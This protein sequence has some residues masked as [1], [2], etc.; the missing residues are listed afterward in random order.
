MRRRDI[1]RRHHRASDPLLA[2]VV[3]AIDDAPIHERQIR[4][5]G[6]FVFGECEPAGD[7]TLNVPL[8]RV[9][10]YLHE[11]THRVRPE[12]TETT[13]RRRSSQLLQAL[14][15]DQVGTLNE[16]LLDAIRASG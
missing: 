2:D 1:R 12:W 13:V 6:L 5:S 14:N 11:G 10:L 8:L 7:I 4:K 16:H 15:D 3:S 9:M